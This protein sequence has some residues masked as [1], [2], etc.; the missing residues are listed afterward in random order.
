MADYSFQNH[1][2]VIEQYDKQKTFASFLPGLAGKRGIPMWA[3]YVNRGQ[4]ISSF[5]LRDKNGAILEF[6]PANLAYL[7]NS[8]IGFR[9]FV[10]TNGRTQELFKPETTPSIRQMQIKQSEFTIR[11]V[12]KEIG[13]EATITYFGLPEEPIA[14][15]VRRVEIKNIRRVPLEL[16]LVDGL[17]QILPSGIDYGGYKAISNLLRSWMDVDN[18]AQSIPF[19]KLRSSTGDEAE[20]KE[21][22]DGNFYLSKVDGTLV[23]PIVDMDLIYGSDTAMNHAAAFDAKGFDGLVASPQYT[24]NKVPCGFTPVKRTLQK[25]ETILIHTLIGYVS[26][27]TLVNT[28]ASEMDVAWFEAKRKA[29]QDVIDTIMQDVKVTTGNPIFDEYVR[30]NH[31]D[32]LLRGG[33]PM[34]LPAGAQDYVYYLYSRKHGDLERDYN[35]FQIAPEFYSQGNGNFRDVCQNR[36]NDVLVYPYTK[37]YSVHMFASLIQTDGYNPLSI[38]G[39]TFSIPDKAKANELSNRLF[40]G[41]Q[42]MQAVLSES[43]TPGKIVNTMA[44]EKIAFDGSDEMLFAQIFPHAVPAIEAN[45]GEGYW[46]DHWTYI[47]DLVENYLHV[48]PD[49]KHSFLY[50]RNDYLTFESPVTVLPRREK[51]VIDKQGN[52]RQYGAIRHPDRE[53]IAKLGLKEHGTNWLKDQNGQVVKTTLF[54]KLVMLAANKFALLDPLQMGIEMEGNKPGWNDAM[55]GLPGLF[56]S[57]LSET[58]E[59]LR[60]IRFLEETLDA[61]QTLFLPV[62]FVTFAKQILALNEPKGFAMWNALSNLK[63]D[64]RNQIRFG[65]STTTEVPAGMFAPFLANANIVLTQSIEDATQLGGGILP[66]YLIYE[67]KAHDPIVDHAG[68]PVYTHYGMPA[69]TVRAFSVKP[70]PIFLEAPARWLKV[71]KDKTKI[72]AMADK[73]KQS[74]VYDAVLGQ[75]KTSDDLDAWGYDIGRIRAFTKGWL[76]R[77]ANFLHMTYK[78]LLGLLKAGQAE[79]FW[80]EAKTNLVCFMDPQVYGRS[81]LENSSFIATSNNP[82]PMVH[83]QGFVSRLSGSTAEMLSI[84]HLAVFGKELYSIQDGQLA[85]KLSP[86]LPADYFK[87]GLVEANFQGT[88]VV[89]HNPQGTHAYLLKPVRYELYRGGRKIDTVEGERLIGPRAAQV[90]ERRFDKIRITLQ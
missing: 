63:E 19:Y 41:N 71:A 88:N 4:G 9:T 24:A 7:Y 51:T 27:I 36:R 20:T 90:R 53:K 62:E 34:S 59:L 28:L 87:N 15:L 40:G 18:M 74:G 39:A 60:L 10:R 67:A 5:G 16:E 17:S 22:K 6:Y 46:S 79:R 89:Y 69:T 23:K 33:Y 57:G 21:V 70:L 42:A 30:Q 3:F 86:L 56:G 54:A 64:Y 45:H 31:L 76:E 13:V 43:F 11:E 35:F 72:A 75:Y 61:N 14:A 1:T 29:A 77:E 78:Y 65:V 81:T 12:N 84:Y 73:I 50:G 52:I 49:Q 58:V 55:N 44:H 37:D 38:N 8:K 25:G 80:I 66:T 47:L 48:Y 85:L 68:S 83:G 32:N 26:D 2:F 82:N